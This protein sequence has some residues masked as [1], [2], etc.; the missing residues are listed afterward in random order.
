MRGV[1]LA[2]GLAKLRGSLLSIDSYCRAIFL[3]FLVL[4]TKR[5][6]QRTRSGIAFADKA[7]RCAA[8]AMA[9][10]DSKEWEGKPDKLKYFSPNPG[11]GD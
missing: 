10:A 9:I 11:E 8:S 3:A 5:G 1:L 4:G 2:D 7:G 6:D